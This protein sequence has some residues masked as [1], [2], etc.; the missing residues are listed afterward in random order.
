MSRI[1]GAIFMLCLAASGAWADGAPKS[2]VTPPP[3]PL[4]PQPLAPAPLGVF[5]ADMPPAGKLIL[6][7][8]PQ[9]LGRSTSLEGAR[10]VS[11]QEIVATTPWF[12]DPRQ[13]LRGVPQSA[14]QA[15]Q[16]VQLAYGVTKVLSIVVATGMTE[17][18]LSFLT[19]KGLSGITPLGM[20]YTGTDSISDTT[21]SAIWRVYEDPINRVQVNVGMSFPTGSNHNTFTLLQP[22]GTYATTR[23]FYAM[24]IGTGTFDAMPGVVYAGQLNNWSWGLSY[25]GRFPLAANPEGYRWGDL[26]EF[27][28]WGG[29]SWIPG[30][31]T[32]FR[33]T[34]SLEGPI[35]GFD[36]NIAGKA[37]AAN[38]KFYGGQRVELF[39][40]A[41]ISGKLVG[42][43]NVLLAIEAG[44]P[45]YQNLNGPQLSK[46]WQ[47][48]LALRFK[49]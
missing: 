37:Q 30:V 46:A 44:L 31:T 49:I 13:K 18:N 36:W 4:P 20:S 8:V 25:R 2:E 9:F 47:A 6:S 26:H 27:T 28:G 16:T 21:A 15:V 12:F 3:Q 38:P 40:G 42:Y 32:T 5:G 48:G 19:F 1:G 24:Q 22:N 23:A 45:V 7:I 43:E 11:S 34:G 35:R 41:T 29:Y 39:G 17:K 33:V 14:L 10:P